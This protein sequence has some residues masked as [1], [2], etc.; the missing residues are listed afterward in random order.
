[1][2]SCD[3]G[4]GIAVIVH[5]PAV[6]VA[7]PVAVAVAVAVAVPVPGPAAHSLFQ[8]GEHLDDAH[9]QRPSVLALVGGREVSGC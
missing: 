9:E 3:F 4:R 7:V 2:D 6:S 8:P 1:G 5:P